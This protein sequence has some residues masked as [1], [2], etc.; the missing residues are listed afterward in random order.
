MDQKPPIPP[1]SSL[2]PATAEYSTA[3][4]AAPGKSQQVVKWKMFRSG[5]GETHLD[6]GK[7]AL[8]SKP[9]AGQSILL[10][11]VKKEALIV[12]AQP[13][14]QPPAPPAAAPGGAPKP[15]A[16]PAA[17]AHVKDLGKRMIGGH[18]AE[19]KLF[20]F[21]PPNPPAPP[22]TPQPPG[23]PKAPSTPGPPG[24]PKAPAVPKPPAMP[25]VAGMPALPGMP[26]PPAIPKPQT[27]AAPAA[28]PAKPQTLEVWTHAQLKVPL[29]TKANGIPGLKSS[30]CKTAKPGEPPAAK[31]QIPP[32]YKLVKPTLPKPPAMPSAP[33]LPKLPA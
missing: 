13:H 30:V 22:A 2:P 14:A 28:T 23:M 33:K 16:P 9:G 27:P 25:K 7:T 8:I 18:P 24:M 10:D 29:L 21:K 32:G 1:S 17:L 4:H 26:K 11:H 19:G 6:F 20:T 3:M 15:P 12:P 31:F 5:K